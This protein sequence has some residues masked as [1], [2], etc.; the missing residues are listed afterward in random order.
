MRCYIKYIL[1][2]L[3]LYHF[4]QFV[5]ETVY[6]ILKAK[7]SQ[8]LTAQI[9]TSIDSHGYHFVAIAHRKYFSDS[10][11]LLEQLFDFVLPK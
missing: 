10:V 2:R 3:T 9:L 8:N 6:N 11:K 4:V 7:Y 1:T 5:M